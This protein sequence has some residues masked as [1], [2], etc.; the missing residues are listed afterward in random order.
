[1]SYLP[2]ALPLLL[3]LRALSPTAEARYVLAGLIL[4]VTLAVSTGRG[5][6]FLGFGIA[7]FLLEIR[8]LPP[9]SLIVATLVWFVVG[10]LGALAVA[11][12]LAGV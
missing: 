10:A 6:V 7:A 8:S 2:F 9:G 5:I 4:G 3:T 11:A 12:A 1:M